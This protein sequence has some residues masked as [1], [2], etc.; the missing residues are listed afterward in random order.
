MGN[1]P[2]SWLPL[3][4]AA[5]LLTEQTGRK[6]RIHDLLAAAERHEC[7]IFAPWT[8]KVK[9]QRSTPL[10]D[11]QNE[12]ESE[13]GAFGPITDNSLRQLL[14]TMSDASM[15]GIPGWVEH[16]W[17]MD[18]DGEP[19][20]VRGDWWA[21]APG[22]V[23]PVFTI[24]QCRI[25]GY[26]LEELARQGAQPELQPITPEANAGWSP[27][28]QNTR[29][30]APDLHAAMIRKALVA[31]GFNPDDLP[32]YGKGVDYP[33]KTK[34]WEALVGTR[35]LSADQFGRGWTQFRKT[36]GK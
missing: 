14:L 29:I 36:G 22:E 30:K 9:L 7:S 18:E 5:E 3:D 34:A 17:V 13:V 31:A 10:P 12:I 1:K 35:R 16:P 25:A 19:M 6:W 26:A 2:P 33:P 20:R 4:V 8:A 28:A 27:A 11:Q 32:T 15:T 24:D 21:L 23:A